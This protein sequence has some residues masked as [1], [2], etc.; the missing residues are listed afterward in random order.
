[1]N[2]SPFVAA[3]A[4]MFPLAIH[5]PHSGQNRQ[6]EQTETL[7]SEI[8]ISTLS[9][10]DLKKQLAAPGGKIEDKSEVDRGE[11]V[12]V[13]VRATGCMKDETGRCDINA[14]VTVYKPDG[15]VFHEAKVLDLSSGRVTVPLDVDANAGTG[16]YR[17][18]VNVRDLTAR[19]FAVVERRFAA[20]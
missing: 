7:Q 20:K 19:R 17:V 13:V 6:S 5:A 14:N 16:L 11:P 3:L 18:V 4:L 2:G 10:E 15:A 12:T 1:M 8:V 9:T